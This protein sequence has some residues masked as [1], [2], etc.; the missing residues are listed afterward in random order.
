VVVSKSLVVADHAP[1]SLESF[2]ARVLRSLHQ[3][4]LDGSITPYA[5]GYDALQLFASAAN[6]VNASDSASI[7]TFIENANFEGLLGTYDYTSSNHEGLAASQ[8]TV[9]PLN[10][11]SNGL[12]VV[13]ASR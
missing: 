11:L 6:G 12:Y 7:R 8:L 3:A 13:T 4:R 5:Q 1:V 9:A 10:S 2:R